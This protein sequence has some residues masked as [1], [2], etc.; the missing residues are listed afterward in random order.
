MPNTFTLQRDAV[1]EPSFGSANQQ[2]WP[3]RI[4]CSAPPTGLDASIF[5][6]HAVSLATSA[7][8]DAFECI[9]S[10]EQMRELPLNNPTTGSDGQ[11]VPYYRLAVLT[12]NCRSAQEADELWGK[13]QEDANELLVNF[14][15]MLDLVA[16]ETVTVDPLA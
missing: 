3:L 10:V 6:Y 13:V 2:T 9:A 14:A 4:T 16:S 7:P 1:P 12:V 15:A 5:V 11:A 8:Q